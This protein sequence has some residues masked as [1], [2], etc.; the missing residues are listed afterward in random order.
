MIQ[1]AK[2][3]TTRMTDAEYRSAVLQFG[4][5]VLLDCAGEYEDALEFVCGSTRNA[6]L[7]FALT[8][9]KFMSG[10]QCALMLPDKMT[11]K[12]LISELRRLELNDDDAEYAADM[13]ADDVEE[14]AETVEETAATYVQPQELE[15]AAAETPTIYVDA[16]TYKTIKSS[17]GWPAPK[18]DEKKTLVKHEGETYLPE[19][20]FD[21]RTVAARVVPRGK[22][23]GPTHEGKGSSRPGGL[24]K[25]GSKEY[26]IEE[27]V[28]FVLD[29]SPIDM[30]EEDHEMT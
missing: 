3:M 9:G 21:F 12:S 20:V 7:R 13:L 10:G 6:S 27:M 25:V 4:I 19:I 1:K 28:D 5:P 24:R 8:H 30:R 22:W 16:D 11:A 17:G 29:G 15:E 23:D 26:V 18:P 2:K 14:A